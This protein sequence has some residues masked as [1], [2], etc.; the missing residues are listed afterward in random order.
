VDEV[1]IRLKGLDDA[2]KRHLAF[3]AAAQDLA[4]TASGG[5]KAVYRGAKAVYLDK[6]KDALRDMSKWLQE[7]Q[8]TAFEVTYQG[9]SKT[10]QD[11]AKGVSI[12]DKLRLGSDER[13]NFR[14]IINV[15]SGLALNQQFAEVSPEY[16]TFPVLV[17]ESNRKQLVGNALK[18]LAGGTRTKDANA[19]LDALEMLDV[20]D[21]G[22]RPYRA[23]ALTVFA[24]SAEPPEGQGTWPGA[25]P[26]RAV[27]RTDRR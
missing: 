1:F 9:K 8:M 11:W 14:D 6:A 12:R 20:G 13:A 27:E 24:R 7:K 21:A 25:E 4:S 19:I 2:I 26:Q 17:T 10:L 23:G 3:Y 5:A 16:P 15:V 18:A 22:W